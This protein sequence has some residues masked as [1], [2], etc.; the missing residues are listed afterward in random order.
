MS[1]SSAALEVTAFTFRSLQFP[2]AAM[3]EARVVFPE[4][5]G[6]ARIRLDYPVLL[7]QVGQQAAFTKYVRLSQDFCDMDEVAYARQADDVPCLFAWVNR[8]KTLF[9]IFHFEIVSKHS[10]DGEQDGKFLFP[11]LLT[12]LRARKSEVLVEF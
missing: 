11:Q 3:T 1:R 12:K 8:A 2:S 10:W 4:P 9:F 5:G 6:P 7:N